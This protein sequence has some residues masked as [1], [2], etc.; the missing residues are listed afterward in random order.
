DDG[1]YQLMLANRDG[2]NTGIIDWAGNALTT[3]HT[4]TWQTGQTASGLASIDMSGGTNGLTIAGS[5]QRDHIEGTPYNDIL[6][7]GNGNDTIISGF[8]GDHFGRDRL[9]G[10]AGNDTL[11]GGKG[12]DY[13]DGGAGRDRLYGGRI[14]DELIGGRGNDRLI[15]GHGND[16]L[17]GGLGRDILNGGRG[18][19]T[20]VFNDLN[21]GMDTVIGFNPN[22]DFLD[23]SGIFSGSEYAADNSFAQYIHYV[24]LKQVGNTTH[25]NVARNGS[26]IGTELT[27]LAKLKGLQ[28]D[29]IS[30][31]NFVME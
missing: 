27:T 11:K 28:A 2:A 26:D 19:D 5:N 18:R 22:Q 8:G 21:D 30:S 31:R 17:N 1:P 3:E 29:T 13:L 14:H 9:Y 23:L 20:I 4:L 24:Q 16:V 15:G 7:G 6:R 10:G 25:V 12:N